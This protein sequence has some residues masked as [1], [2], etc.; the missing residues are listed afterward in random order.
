MNDVI[1]ARF[2]L[3][4]HLLVE[5]A[6]IS[7]FNITRWYVTKNDG[8][9]RIRATLIDSGLLEIAE[10]V[11]LDDNNQII[12]HSYTFHWQ[13]RQHQRIQRWD[14][15]EHYPKLPYAPHHIHWIDETITGNPE[16]PTL[17][18]VLHIIEQRI[19]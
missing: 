7:N 13:D 8:N 3:Y 16:I 11:A 14:N 18:S 19:T 1:D 5:C 15:V 2:R 12:Q 10:Y 4:Q 6:A 17:D 9:I